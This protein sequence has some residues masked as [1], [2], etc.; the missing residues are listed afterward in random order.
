MKSKFLVILLLVFDAGLLAYIY[1]R[2]QTVA[3]L[4]PKGAIALQERDMMLTAILLMLIVI[5]P[6]FILAF[7]VA[8]TYHEKNTKAAFAPDWDHNTKLQIAVW[9]VPFLVICALAY[10]TWGYAHKLDPHVA[11]AAPEKQMT[12]QVVALRWKWLFIYPEQGIATKN[13]VVIPE[14]TPVRFEITAYEAPMNSFWIPQLGGQIY[15][16][17]GMSTTT[18]LIADGVGEYQ[19]STAEISG[20]GFADMRFKAKSL[21]KNDFDAWVASTKQS[22]QDLTMDTVKQLA[23]PSEDRA[24]ASY[25]STDDNLY[26]TIVMQYMAH[27]SPKTSATP[28]HSMED[29]PGM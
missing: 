23:K 17:S 12:I 4:Q 9:G 22:Q 5:V 8:T 11:I 10:L 25:S 7:H 19:G 1:L 3:V 26:T 16:M 21:T 14:K 27:P 28:M 20:H 18:H 2:G 13:Y 29:M 24:T 6:V 15:A